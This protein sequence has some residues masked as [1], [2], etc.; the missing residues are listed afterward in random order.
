MRQLL[1]AGT[2]TYDD[3]ITHGGDS[4]KVAKEW[5]LQDILFGNDLT[6]CSKEVGDEIGHLKI[7]TYREIEAER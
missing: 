3:Q 1:I 7:S 6:L 4:D 2:F 5:F